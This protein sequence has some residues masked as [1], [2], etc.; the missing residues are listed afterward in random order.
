MKWLMLTMAL[1]GLLSLPAWAQG[2]LEW[3]QA[4]ALRAVVGVQSL[5]AQVRLTSFSEPLAVVARLVDASGQ[6]VDEQRVR[7]ATQRDAEKPLGFLLSPPDFG[8]YEAQVQVE[9]EGP[10]LTQGW[11]VLRPLTARQ[12]SQD[13]EDSP[14][15]ACFHFDHGQGDITTIPELMRLAGLRWMRDSIYWNGVEQQ[16]GQYSLPSYNVAAFKRLKELGISTL[17]IL[18]YGN[19]DLYPHTSAEEAE[20]YGHYAEFVARSLA[21]TVDHFELWNEPN[22]FAVLSPDQYPVI[23][24]AGFEGAKAGNPDAF[25]VG[26]A[27]AAPGGWAGWYIPAL[28]EAGGAAWMDSFSVHPYTSPSTADVGYPAQGG[29]A[30][31]ASL[32]LPQAL[33]GGFASAIQQAR[34]FAKRPGLWITELGWPSNAV[35]LAGQA[36]QTARTALLV[37]AMPDDYA[38]VFYYDFLCDGANPDEDEN[39]FG[40]V[41]FDYSPRPAYVAY[42]QATRAVGGRPF[43]R[44]LAHPDNAVRLYLFGPE[45][46][47]LL[48]GW[49][50]EVT[51]EELIAGARA[52]GSELGEAARAGSALGLK[53]P[54]KVNLPGVQQVTVTDWQGREKSV[55]VRGGLLELQL[56]T[57]PQYVGRLG[58]AAGVEAE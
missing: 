30:P 9:G 16:R 58:K 21:G 26:V 50:T 56:S 48:V 8:W 31:R 12:Q 55:S 32:D 27:G 53:R 51:P 42:A 46:D 43:L 57:W 5:P 18:A 35:G 34:G 54:V 11:A 24:K 1:G 14:F 41:G 10:V 7:V 40:L 36:Q 38:R 17:A 19:P 15:G 45:D 25:V 52:D 29:P 4:R 2:R 22:G 6:V 20:A 44:R 33:T 13:A 37:A 3:G 49:V 23:V 47:P 39:N 28:R